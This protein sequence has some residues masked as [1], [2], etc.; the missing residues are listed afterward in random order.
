MPSVAV[1]LCPDANVPSHLLTILWFRQARDTLVACQRHPERIL[2]A[3]AVVV[4]KR[5]ARVVTEIKLGKLAMQMLFA[6][7]RIDA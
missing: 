4:T 3:H 5:N 2:S 6:A 7:V 1:K